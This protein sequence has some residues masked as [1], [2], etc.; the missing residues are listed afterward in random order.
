M[1]SFYTSSSFLIHTPFY[2]NISAFPFLSSTHLHQ[3]SHP[4]SCS[5]PST[6][7]STR[8]SPRCCERLAS[9]A[10]PGVLMQLLHSCN[11]SIPNLQI[12]SYIFNILINLAKYP[13]TVSCVHQVSVGEGEVVGEVRESECVGDWDKDRIPPPP[14][15]HP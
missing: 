3:Y 10:A 13:S 2:L 6:D 8:W 9:E 4:C 14:N 12:I 11:R 5:L 15:T 7:I 1:A